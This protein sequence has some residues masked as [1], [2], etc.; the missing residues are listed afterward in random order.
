M[1]HSVALTKDGRVFEWG[2]KVWLEPNEKT[3]L[4]GHKAVSVTCGNNYSAVTTDKGELFTFGKGNSSALGHG[5]RENQQGKL[6]EALEK[7]RVLSCSAGSRHV[8][9]V[10]ESA[11]DRD[12]SFRE[13]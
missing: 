1:H 5:D 9:A 4:S 10:V 2:R 12:F 3:L 6:V 8:G 11:A 13:V 7:Y